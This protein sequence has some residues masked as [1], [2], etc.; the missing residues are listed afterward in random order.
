MQVTQITNVYALVWW[1]NNNFHWTYGGY[2]ALYAG[3]GVGQ[4]I[5]TFTMGLA[6]GWMAVYVSRNMHY[7][8]VH[9]VFHAPMVFFDR[10]PLG[11]ILGVFGKDIDS[12]LDTCV[13]SCR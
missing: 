10:T 2:I 7:N 5:S 11:R 12:A 3:L 4:A 8:A 6:M 1:Q 9:T 13:S